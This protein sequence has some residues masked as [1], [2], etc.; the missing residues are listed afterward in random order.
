MKK[1]IQAVVGVVCLVAGIT[2]IFKYWPA[3]VTLF[4]GVIGIVLAV[5]GMVALYLLD[6]RRK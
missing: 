5:A 2:L 4:Q 1:I 3:V 6:T